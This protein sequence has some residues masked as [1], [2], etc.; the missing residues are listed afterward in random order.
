[1]IIIY[2]MKW[3]H[4][5]LHNPAHINND[6]INEYL[7]YLPHLSYFILNSRRPPHTIFHYFSPPATPSSPPAQLI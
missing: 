7:Y 2:L 4:Y 1:M 6:L 5:G 3:T